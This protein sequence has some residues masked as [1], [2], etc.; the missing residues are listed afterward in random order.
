MP[1]ILSQEEIDAQFR[2]GFRADVAPAGLGTRFGAAIDRSQAG[3]LGI[4]EAV[5]LPLGDLRREN[6]FEQQQSMQRYFRDNPNEPQSFRDVEGVGS[7]L[8]Y[9]RGLAIDSSPELL[10]SLVTGGAGAL[11]GLGTAG[12]IGLAA[13]ANYPSAVGDILQ[14]Q[15]EEAG[16][17]NAGVA[18]LLGIP[19]AA[20]D[21]VGL[22]AALASG[23][24][25]RTGI[26]RLDE[27]RGFG[28]A[29]ARTGANVA[30]NAPIEGA[31]ET[32]QELVNQAGRMAVNPRQTMFNPEANERY[33]E[34]FVGGATLGGAAS[35]LMGGWRRS[36]QYQ[37]PEQETDLLNKQT[38]QTQQPAPQQY[39]LVT[40]P[41]PL[42]QRIDQQLGIGAR[43]TPKDYAKQFEE[44]YNE[45]SGQYAT[46]P[47]T[48]LEKQ[49]SVGEYQQMTNAP[50]DL[51]E[52][53]P[54]DAAAAAATTAKIERDPKDLFIRD[55]LK[56]IPN[57]HSRTLFDM[58]ME[59]GIDPQ[60]D[61]MVPVWNYA[62][63]KY[64]SKGRYDK[65]VQMMD[66]AIIKA[67]QGAPSG[68][69]VST[70]QQS[71]GGVGVGGAVVP[72]TVGTA[73][74]NAPVTGTVG[75]DTTA[76][77]AASQQAGV[78]PSASGQPPTTVTTTTAAPATPPPSKFRRAPKPM[79]VLE[80]AEAAK[81]AQAQQTGAPAAPPQPVV[82][83]RQVV[84]QQ[85]FGERN[86]DIIFDVVGMGM[87]EPEAAAKYNTSRQN[88]Q[89]IAGATGQK[90][91]PARIA[92][93]KAEKGLTDEQIADAFNVPTADSV[94]NQIASQVF[95]QGQERMDEGQAIEAGLE[96]IV[97]TAGAGTSEVEGFTKLQKEI[98]AT[99]EA[100]ASET[101]EAT[102]E[103]LNKKL[104]EQLVKVRA[105]EEQAKAEVRATA[106][107][108]SKKDE[109]DEA[110]VQAETA[111]P[112]G[113]EDAVQVQSTAVVP[114][115]SEAQTGKGV[116]GQVRRAEKP[117]SKGQ[118]QGQAK[119]QVDRGRAL[120]ESLSAKTPGLVPYEQLTKLE[121]DYLTD[122]AVRTNGKP[123][124]AKEMGLQQLL[125]KE[126]TTI[127]VEA[128][129]I[130]EQVTTQVA[131]LPAPQIDRLEK[132]YGNKRDSAEFLR[133][134][135]E[136][137]TKYVTQG[138][139]AVAGAI[140][141]IIK[142]MAEGVLAMG[143]VFNPN[144]TKDAFNINVGKTFQ[145]TIEVTQEVPAE[146][147]AQMSPT[148][149]A[150]YSAMAPVAMKSGKWFMVADK[151]NGMLHI[152][153]ED[154]SHALSDPTLYGKDKGDVLA[155][156][157]SLEGGAKV[158]PAGKFTLKARA[159]TYAGGQELILVESK[160]Y[161]GYIAIH[162]ADTSTPSE[163]RLGRLD[164]PTAAD[165]RVSY[166]CI[167]TKHDTFINEIKP[168]IS[169]LDGGM[170]FV[171][172]DA[173]DQVAQMFAAETR[174][175]TRTEGGE[176]A[177]GVAAATVVGKEENMLFGKSAE[178]RTPYSATELTNE[179]KNFIRADILGRKLVIVNSVEDLLN[180]RLENEKKIGKAIA[181]ENAYGVADDGTAYLIANRIS[182]GEGRSKFMH[183]VG[184]H[185]GLENLLPS[186]LYRNL[187]SQLA[188][189]AKAND[190]SLEA[191]IAARAQ[192]RVTAAQTKDRDKPAELL[193]Y[194]V[195]EAMLAGID[196]T[197]AGSQTSPLADWF[198]T[199]WAAFKIALRKLGFKPESLDTQDVINLAFG[200]ARLEMNGTW[201]GTAAF[202]RN[203][204]HKFMSSGE[205]AQAYGWGTYLAQ[206]VGVGRGY[207]EAD[208]IRKTW[209]NF[210]KHLENN[211][212]GWTFV[213]PVIQP[214]N[215][216]DIISAGTKI[217]SSLPSGPEFR[218]S[219]TPSMVA[220][221]LQKVGSDIIT[222]TDGKQTFSVYV[223]D[224]MPEGSLMRLDT[225][226]SNDELLDWD[227]PFSDQ[228]KIVRD[229]IK[230]EAKDI[231]KLRA[232]PGYSG[233]QIT[234]GQHIYKYL[235]A[236]FFVEGGHHKTGTGYW[237]G[238]TD[239]V[240]MQVIK[241]AS[242]YL[243]SKGIKGVRLLDADSRDMSLA[244][245]S[246][247]K[248]DS[249]VSGRAAILKAYFTPGAIVQ[250]YG[251]PDKVIKFD[252]VSERITVIAVDNLGNPRRGERQRTHF[253]IPSFNEVAIG[254]QQRGYDLAESTQTRNLVIFDEK[255]IFRIGSEV[256]ADRQRMKF[257]KNAPTQG[258]IQR[259]ISKLPKAAQQPVR[260]SLGA[261]GDAVNKGLDYV[262]FTS[263]LVNR[264]TASGIGSAKKFVDLVGKSK[265]EARENEIAVEK[266]SD[267]Y[268]LVPEKDRGTGEGS[269][270]RFLFDS[271]REGKWG[272]GK[273]RNDD[274]GARFDALS[275]ESQAYVEAVFAHG[276]DMLAKKKKLVLDSTNS[277]YDAMIAAAKA[278]GDTTAEVRLTK[279]KEATLK[280]FQTLFRL[281]DGSPYAPIKRNGSHVVIAKSKEY[282]AAEAANDKKRIT[283]L[284][285][286]S[287]HYHVSF[288]DGKWEARTLQ[289]ELN[290]QGFFD[291]VQ[292]AERDTVIDE[293]F[294]GHSALR[295][296]TKMRSR[297]D[298]QAKDGDKSSSKMLSLISQMYLEA[299]AEGSARKSE[300]RRRGVAGEVDMIRSFAQQGRADANFM[301]SVKYNPQIQDALQEMRNQV[302]KGDRERKSE[303]FNELAKRYVQS[304]DYSPTPW[305]NKL[306]RMSS[307]YYLAT[308][309]AYYLQ[310]LTQPWMMSVPAMAGKYNYVQA[311]NALFKA[312]TELGGVMKSAKLLKQ[313]FDFDK[314]PADVRDAIK[315]LVNR[316]KIDIGLDTEMGEFKVEGD[317][318]FAGK[319]SAA[320]KALRLA[321]QKVESINRLSTAMAAYRLELAKNGSKEDAINYADRI[322]TET[323]GDYTSF[324]AP[325]AFNTGVG[326]VAL[327]FRKF[328]LIQLSFYAKLI[329]DALS[330]ADRAAALK[331]LAYSLGHTG[332]L[333]GVMGLP[334]YSAIAWAIN[335]LLSD[336]DDKYDLTNELRKAIGD[337]QVANLI[338]RGA[339]TL[340]GADI[341]GKVGAGNMLSIM[342]FS[343]ADLT[344]T[345]GRFEAFG[346]LIGGA[347]GGMTSRMID[348][349]LL[350]SSGDW[351]R[352]LEM[353]MPKG[354]SDAMKA[355]RVANE[356]MTRRNGDI[357]L[358][359]D[360]V[361]A[362]DTLFQ[363]IGVQPVEQTVT[364]ERQ[365]LMKATTQNFTERTTRIKNDYVKAA[366]AGDTEGQAEAREAWKKLQDVKRREGVNV[367]P[368][369]D[370]L[371][372]PAEQRKREKMTVGGVQ[373]T[374]G[375][376][377]LAEEIA[378]D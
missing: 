203:F 271:T 75:G 191:T 337:E 119:G 215:R 208:V 84:L 288:T 128:R 240:K 164:T 187:T 69:G 176:G 28:G 136:D 272:Y 373:Y 285:S 326:K 59:S 347:A 275:P 255:N 221:D 99:L 310:N 282:L 135:Q 307:I 256:A 341:S 98:D 188:K 238:A 94:E 131:A 26:K 21:L 87:S 37:A 267:M 151:P 34:S 346:T 222:L 54:A 149:Q 329:K 129:V 92:K 230:S 38:Q 217:V 152:F 186:S 31:S 185:L 148:A 351:Y 317:N 314:V 13:A 146:A 1:R 70:V 138:A 295:E 366:R 118:T 8:R 194:F 284:E 354:V 312:Y 205:G 374:K 269:V 292:V 96:N 218:T 349:L 210:A 274:M 17:T 103:E 27:M 277:E 257:G 5:G 300:M 376:R 73:G 104:A 111:K 270:N 239:T 322:L 134:V 167:N 336:E 155:A 352:G 82:D 52:S 199:L 362:L 113:E 283:E 50:L 224:F 225:A 150:V 173:Q 220:K 68:T 330:G 141:S 66:E 253:T 235:V 172:P 372:A 132:H 102:L 333:A 64:M 9:A 159:S 214:E 143:I 297:V 41:A 338:L 344:T 10:T 309:P 223:R 193:A 359:P 158:T 332:L 100:L 195:E 244:N 306:T 377:K 147:K 39:G 85:I 278:D 228:P 157:S 169:K 32:F 56:V 43:T 46:D 105:V 177:K 90:T 202:F 144:I 86:G 126:P 378:G 252:P 79:T 369:S 236:K 49:L 287:D 117:A 298:A 196:P 273:Y 161:T 213:D 229:F 55:T 209:S 127:D 124:V 22:D 280:R 33:L 181:D 258:V 259:N 63:E 179:I 264:A 93:A 261:M 276:S 233:V 216:N 266:I 234:A 15:R 301:A 315:E 67:R 95:T 356:G 206:S 174:T 51:T 345:A 290:D 154:G 262:V 165:N 42:Q 142:A 355:Y 145:Q 361:S 48:G 265:S 328:Q 7:A 110:A 343:Q 3:L 30:M 133:K 353:T 139:E 308:S 248:G 76:A 61:L 339:P 20:A 72:G 197:A 305:L 201:H 363:A 247:V 324:N 227:A 112:V 370:L 211:Y 357:I 91:W 125:T 183:E 162:A 109:A 316:G 320:D 368:L 212:M 350:M 65:A 180:S 304:L 23:K 36:E 62:A 243:D 242:Q 367:S 358:P 25:M 299:L 78:L 245:T 18:G 11:M 365:N 260:L 88:I 291:D 2:G 334:G 302:K 335:A 60:A 121:Q 153:K 108:K 321:V 120:W 325:R 348:G 16:Q 189:W 168:N 246:F 19:Y 200:A 296:L 184:A 47:V 107:R 123:V 44:A 237:P 375:T 293:M 170:V 178:A 313:Q 327:Q 58:M 231:Q 83:E 140:R 106:G 114:V 115:Q 279:E 342:P 250:G 251:G 232:T 249:T 35:G 77:G 130:D 40:Q 319:I 4:G 74:S 101:D 371:K 311:S 219:I 318:Y 29:A 204:S 53:K 163:N 281:R 71:A 97:K 268:A 116:G 364:Y 166:G 190:G 171:V 81:A 156:V 89:K 24:M 6:Q 80:A 360:E 323:H 14:N 294:S 289:Q 254:M 331:T 286:N 12:R 175:E 182:K 160:D 303:I 263:D 122:L 137:I 207:W 241:Q 192:Q 340:V 226:V 57:Q 198:R 45:P